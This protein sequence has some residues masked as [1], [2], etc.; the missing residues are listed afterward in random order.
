M[1][2]VATSLVKK[3]VTLVVPV[4]N[5]EMNIEAA[6][7][8]I[9][10]AMSR[11][12]DKYDYEIIYT[13]N[14]STDSTF[15]IISRLAAKE[16]RVR[17]VRF[18]MNYGFHRSVL[19]GYRLAKGDAAVQIDCDLQDPPAVVLEFLAKWEEGHDLVF[20]VR[21]MRGDGQSYHWAR[22]VFYRVLKRISN[23]NIQIDS[24]DFRLLDRSILDQISQMHD[25]SPYLRGLTSAISSNQVGVLYDRR[26][27]IAGRSKFP[28]RK[29][30]SLAVDALLAHSVVPLRLATYT[31]LA[32]SVLTF[33]FSIFYIAIKLFTDI[34]MP[35]GFATTTALLLFGI[36]LNAIFL[37]IIGEYIS[38]IY[39]QVRVRPLT[40][41]EKS[42]NIGGSPRAGWFQPSGKGVSSDGV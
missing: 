28:L 30:I 40:V 3:L 7:R 10:E 18:T 36:S 23:D 33:I 24:G 27:R 21:R 4:F 1:Q 2:E 20:G 8:A 17:A 32:I 35:A 6:Y 15:D 29:L 26:P 5:E 34:A 22:S 38:R 11:V 12:A 25:A 14:H 13:D 41:I 37:G 9:D 42:V 39:D 16:S 19:T 31:G